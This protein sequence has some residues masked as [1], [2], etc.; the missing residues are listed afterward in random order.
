MQFFLGKYEFKTDDPDE[1]GGSRPRWTWPGPVEPVDFLDLRSGS[2]QTI[3]KY[4][5]GF[6]LLAYLTAPPSDPGLILDLGD[7]LDTS[8]PAATKG[9]LTGFLNQGTLKSKTLGELLWELFTDKADPTHAAFAKPIMP[10][11][12]G[13]L[14]LWFCDKKVRSDIF[15]AGIHPHWPK[16]LASTRRDFQARKSVDEQGS[17]RY[18]SWLSKKYGVSYEVISEDENFTPLPDGT[19]VTESFPNTGNIDTVSQDN[20]WDQLTAGQFTSSMTVVAGNIV[21]W[22]DDDD[23]GA[24]ICTVGVSGDDHFCEVRPTVDN[25]SGRSGPAV[26]MNGPTGTDDCYSLGCRPQAASADYEILRWADGVDNAVG[27][28]A[29]SNFVNGDLMRLEINGSDIE[30]FRNGVSQLT[31]TDSNLTGNVKG[32]IF[33]KSK[34]GGD[35]AHVGTL[36]TLEDLAVGDGP[37]VIHFRSLTAISVP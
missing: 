25:N 27:A 10:R 32:G 24:A 23:E 21:D 9:L 4:S 33:G 18:L 5:D 26:R 36:W 2:D 20:D 8:I 19:T 14:N 7:S 37:E 15:E 3:K 17:R 12:D 29:G 16:V 35:N 28:S 30:V 31:R 34:L 22:D 13:H 1:L 6:C 11:T